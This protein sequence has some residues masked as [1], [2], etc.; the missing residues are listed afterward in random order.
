MVAAADVRAVVVIV[1]AAAVADRVVARVAAVGGADVT[2]I[3]DPAAK[4]RGIE[5]RTALGMTRE[6]PDRV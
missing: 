1:P 2:A 6:S 4:D 5:P 3:G